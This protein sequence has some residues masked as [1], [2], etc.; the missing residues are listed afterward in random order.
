MEKS[1][2]IKI[3]WSTMIIL[4]SWTVTA[5][6]FGLI[7]LAIHNGMNGITDDGTLGKGI[8]MVA[9]TLGI[10]MAFFQRRKELRW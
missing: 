1:K 8:V 5:I 2:T 9:C 6:G 10:G 3:K 7:G 4:G